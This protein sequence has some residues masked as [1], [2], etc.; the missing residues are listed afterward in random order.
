V[1][2][3]VFSTATS[4]G[5][6]AFCGSAVANSSS[7]VNSIFVLLSFLQASE[8]L[9]TSVGAGLQSVSE[10]CIALLSPLTILF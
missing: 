7:F 10:A 2:T 4:T 8:L 6:G 9:L 3:V 5:V 1:L